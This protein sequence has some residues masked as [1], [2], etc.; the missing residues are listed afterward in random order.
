LKKNDG[1]PHLSHGGNRNPSPILRHAGSLVLKVAADFVD[2]FR[3]IRGKSYR[4]AQAL[5]P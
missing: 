5:A 3:D 2:L 1:P 4:F